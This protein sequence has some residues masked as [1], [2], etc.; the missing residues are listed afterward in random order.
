MRTTGLIVRLHVPC[1]FFAPFLTY[2]GGSLWKWW[3]SHCYSSVGQD[4]TC[5]TNHQQ[6]RNILQRDSWPL[7]NVH[8]FHLVAAMSEV[9]D[10]RKCQ[11]CQGSDAILQPFPLCGKVF[12]FK[13]V[14]PECGGACWTVLCTSCKGKGK[15]GRTLNLSFGGVGF[16]FD[17][18]EK[19]NQCYGWGKLAAAR[20]DP[21]KRKRVDDMTA[22]EMRD[23]LR[24]MRRKVGG[25]KAELKERLQQVFETNDRGWAMRCVPKVSSGTYLESGTFRDVFLVTFTKGPRKNLKGVYKVFKDAKTESLIEED[26]QAV[27]EAGRIIEAFNQYNEEHCR[28][29]G[30]PARR[31]VYLNQP[32]VWKCGDRK[33]LVEPLIDGTYAK[34]NSNSGWVSMKATT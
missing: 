24:K 20:H 19:C 12:N 21:V 14:C 31:R 27:A 16:P 3:S 9:H 18:E 28:Q 17:V 5:P 25:T 11:H 26:L 6:H 10:P 8:G 7:R 32:E 30:Q 23:E 1:M 33:V 15:T 29:P 13:V 4:F 2:N 22:L 34:F